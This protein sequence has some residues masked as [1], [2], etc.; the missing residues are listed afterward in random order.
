MKGGSLSDV[1]T[2][3]GVLCRPGG[4]GKRVAKIAAFLVESRFRSRL[5]SPGTGRYGT[6]KSCLRDVT[7]TRASL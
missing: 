6:G 2:G 5:A 1:G 4:Q 3:V 7:S